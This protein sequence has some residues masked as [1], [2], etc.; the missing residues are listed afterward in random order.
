MTCTIVVKNK[1]NKK[2]EFQMDLKEFQLK[3]ILTAA[4]LN[5]GLYIAP[6]SECIACRFNNF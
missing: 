1:K 4:K 3:K 5:S 2:I 6:L